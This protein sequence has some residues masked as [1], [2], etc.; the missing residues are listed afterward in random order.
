MNAL[1]LKDLADKTR[2]GLRGRVEKGKP[3]GGLAYGYKVARKFSPN[4]EA[5]KGDRE[6]DQERAKI[7]RRIFKEYALKNKSPKVIAS[8]LNAFVQIRELSKHKILKTLF[9]PPLKPISCKMNWSRYS[10]KNIK[11]G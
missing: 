8:D 7:V 3:G 5:I 1:F 11:A 2:R 6:I 10:V 4:G 9:W